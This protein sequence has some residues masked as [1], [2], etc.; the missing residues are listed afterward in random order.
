MYPFWFALPL[1]GYPIIIDLLFA[2]H[3]GM[4]IPP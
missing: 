1:K 3:H 4:D 2:L